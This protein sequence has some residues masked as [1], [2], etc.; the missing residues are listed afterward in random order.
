[1]KS[2][3]NK[4]I[5][6]ISGG[7][8]KIGGLWGALEYIVYEKGIKPNVL[9]GISSGSILSYLIA[10]N[11]NND[12]ISSI[13][14]NYNLNTFFSESPVNKKGNVRLIQLI[15]LLVFKRN[16]L[17]KMN[18]LRKLLQNIVTEEMHYNMKIDVFVGSVN[19]N[20]G[21]R[22]IVNLRLETYENA[23]NHIIASA[24]IPFYTKPVKLYNINDNYFV[25]GGVRDHILSSWY[26]EHYVNMD[27]TVISI[28]SRP[29]DFNVMNDK[30]LTDKRF[31]VLMNSIEI[32]SLEISK[33]NEMIEKLLAKTKNF[34]HYMVFIPSVMKSVYDI[35]P[36]RLAN[37]Y[38]KGRETAIKIFK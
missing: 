3:T 38:Y 35:N 18:N 21:V 28:Y 25:D 13:V 1:M 20:T 27:D 7:G 23:I 8:T 6:N 26:C 4:V 5:I 29:E 32:M 22:E 11:V 12:D 17:G 10:N 37:I 2:K 14:K 9:T 16:Y 34:K 19:I 31:G 33:K 15:K 36:T 24:S 30:V